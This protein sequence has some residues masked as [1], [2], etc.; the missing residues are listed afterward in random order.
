M[1]GPDSWCGAIGGVIH[2]LSNNVIRYHISENDGRNHRYGG[3]HMRASGG[4]IYDIN[5]YIN[6]L[7]KWECK[8]SGER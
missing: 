8:T 4:S 7:S 2:P 6:T 5:V 1:T 3:V